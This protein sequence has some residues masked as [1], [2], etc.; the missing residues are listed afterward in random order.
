MMVAVPLRRPGRKPA[1]AGSRGAAATGDSAI[2][3]YIDEYPNLSAYV[4]SGEMR[5][6]FTRA[7][8]AQL[9]VFTTTL[10]G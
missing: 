3:K 8:A 2:R 9:A 5:A 1:R 4:A 6:A 7:F 10:S